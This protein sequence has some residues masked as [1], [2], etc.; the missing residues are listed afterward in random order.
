MW[1]RWLW[2]EGEVLYYNTYLNKSQNWGTSPF[3]WY[4]LV[5]IPKTMM[6]T[7][8]FIPVGLFYERR[9]LSLVIPVLVFVFLYSFLPHKELRFIFY[10]F[11][12]LN[13]AAANGISRFVNNVAK[14]RK[15]LVFPAIGLLLLSLIF[16]QGL[17]YVSHYNYPGGQAFKRFHEIV[18]PTE[19]VRVHI[20]VP[21][22]QTGV[23]RFGQLNDGNQNW[24][25]DKTENLMAFD[26]FTHVITSNQTIVSQHAKFIVLDVISSFKGIQRLSGFPFVR[27]S[28]SE[29]I[30]I[31][32][33][34]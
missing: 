22:A 5:A 13:L 15:Y 26:E 28:F 30:Y 21:A 17:L 20:D 34:V 33:R 8:A 7:L 24:I 12:V 27:P 4:F 32:K 25:Y 14:K 31:H 3:Y 9:L 1:G 10:A 11:P 2:P 19:T 6:T 29:S 23:S 16:T 18:P